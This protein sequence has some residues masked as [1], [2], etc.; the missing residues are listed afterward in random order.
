MHSPVTNFSIRPTPGHPRVDVTFNL[1]ATPAREYKGPSSANRKAAA[2][3]R[4]KLRA[5]KLKNKKKR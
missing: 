2:A 3:Y 5:K 4:R 1:M